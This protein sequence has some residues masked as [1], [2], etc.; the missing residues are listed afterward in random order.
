MHNSDLLFAR[1][2]YVRFSSFFLNAN[3]IR[4]INTQYERW[5]WLHCCVNA[6]AVVGVCCDLSKQFCFC[7][8]H[9]NHCFI[10]IRC[11]VL[12]WTTNNVAD[13]D[14]SQI[15]SFFIVS[16]L[17]RWMTWYR[18]FRI[19]SIEKPS[20]NNTCFVTSNDAFG[21]CARTQ[22]MHKISHRTFL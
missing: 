3:L 19:Q 22:F 18:F 12:S 13:D 6:V 9:T 8:L 20:H 14:E 4:Q 11:A 21:V 1:W 16:F 7:R 15:V 5:Y 10:H 2:L 17:P